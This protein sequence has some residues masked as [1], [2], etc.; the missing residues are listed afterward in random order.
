[1]RKS[2][3]FILAAILFGCSYTTVKKNL[4]LTK[5]SHYPRWIKSNKLASDQTSGIAF[6]GKDKKGGEVFLL[7]DDIG[8]IQHLTIYNDT[9]FVLS[10]VFLGHTVQAYLDTFPKED[11][12]EIVYD[13]DPDEIYLSIEGNNPDPKKFVGIFNL[14]F[15]D[16][17]VFSDTVDSI[18][19][20]YFQPY[21]L[22]LK[23][24]ENNIGYEG[25]AVDSN[26]FY[27]GLEGFDDQGVFA[28]STFLFIADKKTNKI[29]KQI[30]TK[31]LG[32]H[33][34]CGLYS[35]K[36]YS[37]YG[38]DRNNKRIFHIN[39]DKNLNIKDYALVKIPTSIPGYPD[40]DYVASLESI[41]MDN[42]RNFYLTDDPWKRF[43]IPSQVILNK[44]DDQ[45]VKNFKDFI[46]VIYKFQINYN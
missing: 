4:T 14:G 3:I 25:L 17:N 16:N 44:L 23:Y 19:K 2:T 31:P 10:N 37:L 21:D 5:D 15:K 30:N 43:F 12:E 33:T 42:D 26:Y 34:I 6:L 45:T 11:F 29:I 46:P 35:D 9:D 32:I 27:L 1:V 38:V 39:F 24:V 22:F 20:L 36:N 13:K 28:D 18:T 41:T 40:Y 7:A 8:L